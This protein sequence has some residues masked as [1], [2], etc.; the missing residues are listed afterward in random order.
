M[1]LVTGAAGFIGSNVVAVLNERGRSDVVVC[2]WLG[3]DE[4]WLNLRKRM[5]RNFIFPEDLMAFLRGAAGIEAVVHMGANSSTTAR[6]GD[7]IMRSNFQASLRLLDWC[8]AEGVPLVYASSAATYGNG[9]R[10][11]EDGTSLAALRELRPLNLYGWSKHQFDL[12]FAERLEKGLPLPPKCIGLKFFNVFGQNEYHKGD[13]MSVI[14]KNYQTAREGG[15][16]RLFKSHRDGIADGGQRRD[17]I[18]VNDVIDV[19]LWCLESGPRSGLLNVGTGRATSFRELIE[20][21][22]EAV[23]QPPRI[24]YVPMPEALRDRY[25]YWT[26]ASLEGLR[27]AGYDRQF[28]PISRAVAD[29]VTYLSSDDRYR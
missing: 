23:G 17:F 29:Y 6:D 18:S 12:V 3:G 4:R 21:L 9:T 28:T 22:Y 7:A 25:Q 24:A 2:D 20:A 11:F 13:M 19:I 1:I 26:Q 10:G 8:A 14:A 16:V 5:F 27:A 15:E